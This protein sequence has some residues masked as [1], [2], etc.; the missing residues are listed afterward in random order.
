MSESNRKFRLN[1]GVL[2]YG[3][4][5][6]LLA[7]AVLVPSIGFAASNFA[8]SA[9]TVSLLGDLISFLSAAFSGAAVARSSDSGRL[10]PGILI[11]CLL[12]LILALTGFLIGGRVFRPDGV[13]SMLSFTLSGAVFGSVF[14]GKSTSVSKM[15]R[16]RSRFHHAAKKHKS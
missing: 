6:W 9:R 15:K 13:L 16:R 11:G 10:L 1:P 4:T 14:F 2:L 3:L 8:D 12:A 5:T 7:S